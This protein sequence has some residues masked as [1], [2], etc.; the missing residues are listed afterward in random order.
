M[1]SPSPASPGDPRHNG[2]VRDGARRN[3]A[4]LDLSSAFG[5]AAASSL[6][7]SVLARRSRADDVAEDPPPTRTREP[8]REEPDLPPPEVVEDERRVPAN[9]RVPSAGRVRRPVASR[10]S[11]DPAPRRRPRITRIRDRQHIDMLL[12]AMAARG[13]ATGR[14]LV[15]L[16]RGRSG[17]VF[18]LSPATVYRELH[19]LRN[20]RLMQDTWQSGSRRYRLTSFGERVLASRR[21]EWQTFSHGMNLVLEAAGEGGRNAPG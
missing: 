1:T 2:A 16:V 8:V 10:R 15:D 13:P 6:R 11:H 17:G 7:R 21:R 9:R 12:L 4:V 20:D 19:R 5:V 18:V 14:E 3:G